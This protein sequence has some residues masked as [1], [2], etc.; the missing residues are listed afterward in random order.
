M[1]AFR[2]GKGVHEWNSGKI[3]EGEWKNSLM[4]GEGIMTDNGNKQK[5]PGKN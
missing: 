2:H 1:K 4:D 3:Y 5:E